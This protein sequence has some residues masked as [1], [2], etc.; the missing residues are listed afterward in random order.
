MLSLSR[1]KLFV[2]T[3][4]II[5]YLSLTFSY[6]ATITRTI[7]LYKFLIEIRLFY[8]RIYRKSAQFYNMYYLCRCKYICL[9]WGTDINFQSDFFCIYV[10]FRSI[11]SI[12]ANTISPGARIY[13]RYVY[14]HTFVFALQSSIQHFKYIKYILVVEELDYKAKGQRFDF[15]FFLLW[16][17]VIRD[18]TIKPHI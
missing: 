12:I 8:T 11:C 3:Y 2:K 13:I 7:S 16:N 6:Y 14:T 4:V 18:Y 10:Y 17:P 5:Y 9:Y 15:K 1:T